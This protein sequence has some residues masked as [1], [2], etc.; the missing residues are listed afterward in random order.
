MGPGIGSAESLMTGSVLY[1]VTFN[2]GKQMR[3]APS[4]LAFLTQGAILSRLCLTWLIGELKMTAAMRMS[5]M[6]GNWLIEFNEL[7]EL[8]EPAG[9]HI[10]RSLLRG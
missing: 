10:P 9:E 5:F 7:I 3:S 2:S 8:I 6:G 1:P 4:F